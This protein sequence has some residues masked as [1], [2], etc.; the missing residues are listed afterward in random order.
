[1]VK[2][3]AVVEAAL[4]HDTKEDA[5][6]VLHSVRFVQPHIVVECAVP[7]SRGS[8][9]QALRDWAI[10]KWPAPALKGDIDFIISAAIDIADDTQGDQDG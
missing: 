5:E 8:R 3:Y 2:K 4:L 10:Q 7:E 1:M 9:V 6:R